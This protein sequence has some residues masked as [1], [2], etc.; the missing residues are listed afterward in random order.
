MIEGAQ[1][2]MVQLFD[3]RELEAELVGADKPSDLAVIRIKGDVPDDL[4]PLP[5]GDSEKL[6]IGEWVVAVGAP[7]GLM[8]P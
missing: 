2:I 6:Q 3:E 7:F 5:F 1:K 4:A 8:K